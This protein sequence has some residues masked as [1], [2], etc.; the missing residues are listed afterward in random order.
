[1]INGGDGDDIIEG[2]AGSDTLVG[3]DNGETNGD[4]LSYA[5]SP[6]GE[7]VDLGLLSHGILGQMASQNGPAATDAD[8]D[9]I[10]GFENII[11]TKFEDALFGSNGDVVNRIDGGAGD[12]FIEG[13][14]GADLLI[15]GSNGAFGDTLNYNNSTDGVTVDLSNQA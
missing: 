3:G 1:S 9:V 12:D 11:G 5:N 6:G 14:G 7:F 2:G 10:S 4:T 13:G 15:G 8:G